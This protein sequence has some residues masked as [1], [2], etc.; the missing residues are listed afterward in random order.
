MISVVIR[1]R[2]S[3][4]KSYRFLFEV[5][6]SSDKFDKGAVI[7]KH[8]RSKISFEKQKQVT[9]DFSLIELLYYFNK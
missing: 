2:P 3:V 5:T 7:R 1:V 4:H 8:I 9:K 6:M